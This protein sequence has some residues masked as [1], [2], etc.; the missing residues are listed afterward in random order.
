MMGCTLGARPLMALAS[1]LARVEL[2]LVESKPV[3][4][5]RRREV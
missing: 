5:L 3:S 2:V 4:T 1:E